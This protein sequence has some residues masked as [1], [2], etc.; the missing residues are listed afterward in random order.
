MYVDSPLAVNASGIF[1][2]H[3][4][5]FDAGDAG[6]LCTTIGTTRLGFDLLTYTR[7]VEESK[8]LNERKD[9]MI[10]IS[11][12]GMAEQ[13]AN[14]APPAE[15]YRGEAQ[16]DPDRVVAGAAHA[17]A[18]AGG[19]GEAGDDFWGDARGAGGGGD[20]RGV[21]GARGAGFLVEYARR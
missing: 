20:D 9:P 11:A 14:P 1:R 21:L 6:S 5:C 8:A 18:A 15:Q 2:A 19:P 16:Y 12:S 3:P 17:G 7:S 4:E 13:R 10:I